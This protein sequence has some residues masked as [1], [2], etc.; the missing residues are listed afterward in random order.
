MVAMLLLLAGAV[1]VAGRLSSDQD[2]NNGSEQRIVSDSGM[3]EIIAEP[4]DWQRPNYNWARWYPDLTPDRYE[5]FV[6]IPD[7][8]TTT[9]NAR[10]WVSHQS[11]FTLR[12]VN[13]ST[14]GDRWVSLGTFW[15]RGSSNDYVS[16]ADITHERYVSRLIAFDAVKWEP[17]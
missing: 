11:G 17:R 7:R 6:Y 12:Q 16:L 10:Y 8:Y 4:N 2:R 13:Q 14:T 9:S 1:F 3:L 5:V 15:F